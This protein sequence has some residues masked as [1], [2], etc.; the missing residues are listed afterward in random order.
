[1]NI[2]EIEPLSSNVECE[3]KIKA[4]NFPSA[5][6]MDMT[7]GSFVVA[8]TDALPLFIFQ[9]SRDPFCLLSAREFCE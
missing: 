8:G 7:S 1:M 6:D 2:T 9:Y 3:V 5:V 4:K